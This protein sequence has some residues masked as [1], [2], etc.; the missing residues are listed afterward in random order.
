ML[1]S[2]FTITYSKP[3]TTAP[4]F[5]AGSFTS[6]PW[7]PQ[8]LEQDDVEGSS[9]FSRTFSARPGTYQ[10]KFRLGTGDW[11]VFAETYETG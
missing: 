7:E 8:E 5:V 3:G 1:P 2:S 11:W 10:Y 4:V 9:S 6:P